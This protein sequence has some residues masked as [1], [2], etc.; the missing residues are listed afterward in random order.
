MKTKW[1][2]KC[3]ELLDARA[4]NPDVPSSDFQLDLFYDSPLFK[5]S[6]S[7]L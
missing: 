4:Y 7:H 1:A 6:A 3:G 2:L 5:F